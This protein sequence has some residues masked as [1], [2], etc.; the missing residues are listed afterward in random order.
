MG[1]RLGASSS[2]RATR[3]A[4]PGALRTADDVWPGALIKALSLE[5]ARLPLSKASVLCF[6]MA[7][8]AEY[9]F[10]PADTMGTGRTPAEAPL[11]KLKLA[12]VAKPP[13]NEP[14][15]SMVWLAAA[16]AG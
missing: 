9:V 5:E 10:A 3:G 6:S 8:R 13:G 1:T 2:A 12:A 11:L 15:G 7:G 14:A 16:A 4:L